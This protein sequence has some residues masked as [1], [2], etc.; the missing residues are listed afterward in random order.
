MGFVACRWAL[1]DSA[2]YQ[3]YGKPCLRTE[4]EMVLVAP[5]NAGCAHSKVSYGHCDEMQC[6]NYLS[7]CPL[8]AYAGTG[9]K[10]NRTMRKFVIEVPIKYVVAADAIKAVCDRF[11]L[12][13]H[14]LGEK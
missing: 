10:C 11:Q 7:R 3:R 5:V 9:D 13:V 8:H 1:Q 2:M 12:Q 6:E 4:K 14:E